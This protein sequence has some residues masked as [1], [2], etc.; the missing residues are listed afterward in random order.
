METRSLQWEASDC[1][2]VLLT[3]DLYSYNTDYNNGIKY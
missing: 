3:Y 2:L 1:S